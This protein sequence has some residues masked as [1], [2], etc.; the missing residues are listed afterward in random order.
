MCSS[1]L[2]NEILQEQRDSQNNVSNFQQKILNKLDYIAGYKKLYNYNED[3]RIVQ[4]ENIT[5]PDDIIAE[6]NILGLNILYKNEIIDLE[7]NNIDDLNKYINIIKTKYLIDNEVITASIDDRVYKEVEFRPPNRRPK[8]PKDTNE[9]YYNNNIIPILNREL[10]SNPTNIL[11]DLKTTEIESSRLMQPEI[12]IMNNGEIDK[13]I[14]NQI[15]L[16]DEF[17]IKFQQS[18][19]EYNIEKENIDILKNKVKNDFESGFYLGDGEFNIKRTDY[20]NEF[21]INQS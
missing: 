21:G 15:Y 7:N 5:E 19:D 10:G 8:Y 9:L 4:I 6:L 12:Y 17:K 13:N 16:N 3:K 11:I 20:E 2:L 14:N 18:V 1:D